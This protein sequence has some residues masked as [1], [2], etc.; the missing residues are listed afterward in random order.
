[1]PELKLAVFP[2]TDDQNP[3][4]RLLRDA[5]GRRGVRFVSTPG[6]R[7]AWARQAAQEVD[8]VHLHWLE[9]L[10]SADGNPALRA[11]LMHKRAASLLL[12]LRALRSAPVR[13]V[14]TVHNLRPHEA[15][16]PWLGRATTRAALRTS[17]AIVVHSRHAARRLSEELELPV[18][19]A[20][21][22]HPH[23]IGTYPEPRR[24]RDTIRAELGIPGDGFAY[25]MFGQVRRYKR[26]PEAIAAFRRLD[27]AG[28]RLVVAGGVHDADL[29]GEIA[30]ARDGDERVLLRLA[31][32][33][34]LEVSELHAAADAA[35]LH[36]RDVFSS[37]ALLLALSLGLPVV[38]PA[39][40]TAT[41]TA[42]P[43]AV[44]PYAGDD[45]LPALTAVRAGPP[46]PRREAALAA[47]R[48]FG[49]DAMADSL[50]DLYRGDR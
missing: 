21:L 49:W 22:P 8:A 32:V 12:A 26:V 35:L 48:S 14:W 27:D 34:E 16:A 44:E 37:G 33:P 18:E 10:Y 36:Y 29:A 41:E 38:A 20:V 24:D 46:E 7:S 11:A 42:P 2:A 19:P 30:A 13:V 23:Y 6:L 31:P 25:L 4:S 45:P 28:A 43:P 17:D 3:Y 5:L 9:F 50:V 39:D 15:R 40:T 47:A 1:V